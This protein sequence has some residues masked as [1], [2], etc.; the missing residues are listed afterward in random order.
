MNM[1]CQGLEPAY[2][3]AASQANQRGNIS[4]GGRE[5][6]PG[7]HYSQEFSIKN[8]ALDEQDGDV[9]GM[10]RKIGIL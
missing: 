3:L 10:K 2:Y 9:C 6:L 5:F 4:K 8:L 1:R 7:L